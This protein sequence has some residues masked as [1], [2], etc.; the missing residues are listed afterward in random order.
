MNP[1]R[2]ITDPDFQYTRSDFSD[3]RKTFARVRQQMESEQ[4]K[5]E[6]QPT[7]KGHDK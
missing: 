4:P 6:Q 3:I 5:P 7:E 2:R 1:P